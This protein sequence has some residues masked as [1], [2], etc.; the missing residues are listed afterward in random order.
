MSRVSSY[1]HEFVRSFPER[2]EDGMLY[3]SID[4][5]TAAHRCCCGCGQ[6]V[7]TPL[8]PRDWKM[9]YDGDTVSLNPSI[10]NWSFP[11]Q[12]HYWLERGRVSW[13]DR[14]SKDQIERGRGYDR[15]RK[16]DHYSEQPREDPRAVKKRGIVARILGWIVGR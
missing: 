14:W 15:A 10:G 13:A 3:V 6:D 5:D 16:A 1:T 12:S 4:F 9:I 8:S 7:Y 2:L 11:C